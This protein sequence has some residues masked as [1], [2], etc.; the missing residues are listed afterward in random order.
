MKF[1][2]FVSEKV[3]QISMFLVQ[4]TTEQLLFAVFATIRGKISLEKN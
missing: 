2:K 1:W 3:V 4:S